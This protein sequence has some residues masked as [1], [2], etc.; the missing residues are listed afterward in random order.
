MTDPAEKWL[1]AGTRAYVNRYARTT[2]TIIHAFL[3]E[4]EKDVYVLVK[5]PEPKRGSENVGEFSRGWNACRAATLASKVE[6]AP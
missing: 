2:N 1:E 3:A 5:V 4:A 6:I